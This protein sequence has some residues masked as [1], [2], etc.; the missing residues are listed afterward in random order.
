MS[1][2]RPAQLG[3]PRLRR[4]DLQSFSL[5]AQQPD[6]SL[7][8]A[9]GVTCLAGANGIGKSTFLSAVTFALTGRVPVPHRGY[10]SA[11]EYY[12]ESASFSSDFFSGRIHENDRRSSSISIEFE[13]RDQIFRITRGLFEGNGLRSLAIRP[14]ANASD[15]GL[16]DDSTLSD[17]D[18]QRVYATQL[19]QAMGLK[20]FDQFVFLQHFVFTFDESRRLL[21]WNEKALEAALFIAFGANPEHQVAADNSRREMERA[22]SLGRNVKWQ[23]LQVSKRIDSLTE[24]TR[25]KANFPE[26]E[27]QYH[28]LEAA[29]DSTA[30]AAEQ[31]DAK[32]ADEDLALANASAELLALRS[33]YSKAFA[34]HI[35]KRSSAAHHPLVVE[36]VTEARCSLCG[37]TAPSVRDSVARR[38]ASHVCPLCETPLS[39]TESAD[40]ATLKALD[41]QLAAAQKRLES[42]G[43]A[44]SRLAATRDQFR[45]DAQAAAAAIRAF[46]EQHAEIMRRLQSNNA[47]RPEGLQQELERLTI[48]LKALTQTSKDHYQARD[49]HKAVLRR[50]QDELEQHYRAAEVDFVPIFRSLAERFIGI[51]LDIAVER[52]TTGVALVLEFR[53]TRR[54]E[55]YELSES[56]R[57]FLDIALRMALAQFIS[58]RAAPA[59]LYIDT[60][61]GSLDIAYEARAGEMFAQ[62][63]TGGHDILMTANINSSQLLRKLAGRCGAE[64]MKLVRMTEWAELSE[65]QVE[66]GPLFQEAYA[67]IEK[68][69]AS[70]GS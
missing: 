28:Q 65:V 52:R 3:F 17:S 46:E 26:L 6:V 24:S 18:R 44:R 36:A 8:I 57:F 55:L 10:S 7:P 37:V 63:V 25:A 33:E 23:A 41:E 13:L 48:E 34:Q 68:D 69:L 22:E 38:I 61:E 30:H 40:I 56:Q 29:R 4:V 58:D 51:D 5:Y 35:G 60:P 54:R 59:P 49:Q 21:F 11:D 1:E 39:T 15:A 67:I 62:F 9:R 12:Q 50:L 16:A 2:P 64:R 20:S 42:A 31:A 47:V 19:T 43:A 27:A 45:R 14:I 70:G 66:E 32:A 53:S